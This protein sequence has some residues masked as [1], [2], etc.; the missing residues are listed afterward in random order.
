MERHV[1]EMGKELA[2]MVATTIFD[3]DRSEGIT[4]IPV[5]LGSYQATR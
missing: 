3:Q 5:L 1:E 4:R 2:A